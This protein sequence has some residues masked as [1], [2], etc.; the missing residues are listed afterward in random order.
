MALPIKYNH[1]IT[2]EHEIYIDSEEII[3]SLADLAGFTVYKILDENSC[4]AGYF[5]EANDKD[6]R[7]F[8]AAESAAEQHE[9]EIV[10]AMGSYM[11][12]D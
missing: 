4:F 9:N 10:S 8:L 3:E 12:D 7:E 1:Q 11:G 6:L 2:N 5:M